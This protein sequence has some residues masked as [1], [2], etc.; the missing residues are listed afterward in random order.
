[1]HE[2]CLDVLDGGLLDNLTSIA[3]DPN[4]IYD[5]YHCA[6]LRGVLLDLIP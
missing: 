5:E 6:G 1:M 2:H 4:S 3:E